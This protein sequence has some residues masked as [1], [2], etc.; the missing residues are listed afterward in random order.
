VNLVET[1]FKECKID[2]SNKNNFKLAAAL[3]SSSSAASKVASNIITK[4]VVQSGE[5]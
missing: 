3:A 4:H 2:T 1:V 5:K